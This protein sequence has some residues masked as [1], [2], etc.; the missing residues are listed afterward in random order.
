MHYRITGIVLFCIINGTML[1]VL[2][3]RIDLNNSS[4]KIVRHLE[5]K[6]RSQ[7]PHPPPRIHHDDDSSST[8]S[9]SPSNGGGSGESGGGSSGGDS[10]SGGRSSSSSSSSGGNSSSNWSSN[11]GGSGSTSSNYDYDY[12]SS[13]SSSDK[14]KIQNIGT[15]PLVGIGASVAAVAALAFFAKNNNA[16]FIP[17]TATTAQNIMAAGIPM[18]QEPYLAPDSGGEYLSY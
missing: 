14:F 8:S 9:G 6:G 13:V 2:Y 12:V 4:S 15:A 10:S 17:A 1:H 18:E 16:S 3:K 11:I 7:P 5:D